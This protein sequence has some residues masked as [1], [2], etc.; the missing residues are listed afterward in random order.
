MPLGSGAYG[1]VHLAWD[2]VEDHWV[3]LK[4]FTGQDELGLLRMVIE[5]RIRVSHPHLV[6]T[7]AFRLVDDR[8]W[9]V[10]E[11][12]RGGS[13][14]SLITRTGRLPWGWVTEAVDQILSALTTLHATGV[15][16]R[17]L[18]PANLL[19][20]SHGA[21]HPHLLVG[22]FGIATWRTVSMT[23]IGAAIGTPGYLAP[24]Y[25]D[26]QPPSPATDLFAV[27]VL[28]AELLTGHR[29]IHYSN[30]AP[31][32]PSSWHDVIPVPPEVPPPLATVLKRMASP[33]PTHRYRDC[34]E[35]REAL[36]AA[37]PPQTRGDLTVVPVPDLLSTLPPTWTPEGPA[38]PATPT[39][40][41][42]TSTPPATEPAS[43]ADT[44]QPNLVGLPIDGGPTGLIPENEATAASASPA[45]SLVTPLPSPTSGSSTSPPSG[46][47]TQP[48]TGSATSLATRESGSSTEPRTGSATHPPT[49]SATPPAATQSGSATFPGTPPG[50]S[51]ISPPTPPNGSASSH[52]SPAVAWPPSPHAATPAGPA[53]ASPTATVQSGSS[54]DPLSGSSTQPPIGSATFPGTPPGGSAI[55]PATPPNGSAS[56]PPATPPRGS[57]TPPTTPPSGSAAFPSTPSRGTDTKAAQ[58]QA[59]KTRR[60]RK[61]KQA[62]L[63][64][65][66]IILASGA[67]TLWWAAT[68]RS[69]PGH[70]SAAV[71]GSTSQPHQPASRWKPVII[72]PCDAVEIGAERTG[73]TGT[74]RCQ[75]TTPA[76]DPRQN[77]VEEP[78]GGFPKSDPGGP[79]PAQPCGNDGDTHYSPVGDHLEC[80]DGTW[81]VIA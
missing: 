63:L 7:L 28:A 33:D 20:R 47:S 50:G 40:T 24:E 30:A 27:G 65:V 4:R 72:G 56:S 51:A 48:P 59:R 79:F 67:G 37:V 35:A 13:L 12:A 9:L 23:G 14:R 25:L 55:S 71:G 31:T 21:T 39:T 73:A 34:T 32:I 66:L 15:V 3:A 80:T 44:P 77:W 43:P 11:L 76:P 41:L 81:Q 19:L 2:N 16:H 53:D 57:A 74:E 46:S 45:T 17:D 62:L 1:E 10:T 22:D 8:A 38:A 49:G 70:G 29:L 26:G 6:R 52:S 60:R 69:I 68:H 5:S 36:L 78:P 75:Y 42:P 54:T 64:V 58:R 18:K 61:A